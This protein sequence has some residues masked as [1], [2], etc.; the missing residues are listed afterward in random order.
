MLPFVAA[1]RALR[2]ILLAELA[3]AD[4]A[5][6]AGVD[7]VALGNRCGKFGP[8]GFPARLDVSAQG[9]GSSPAPTAGAGRGPKR[10]QPGPGRGTSTVTRPPS[11]KTTLQPRTADPEDGTHPARVDGAYSA[12]VDGDLYRAKGSWAD[13]VLPPEPGTGG[14]G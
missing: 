12:R 2:D 1:P 10:R 11:P 13:K 7:L 6:D 3:D 14:H 9:S 5:G 8:E 4:A